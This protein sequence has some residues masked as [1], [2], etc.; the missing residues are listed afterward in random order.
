MG[1]LSIDAEIYSAKS[2]AQ[3]ES[4]KGFLDQKQ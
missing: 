2:A 1:N 4:T 3:Y